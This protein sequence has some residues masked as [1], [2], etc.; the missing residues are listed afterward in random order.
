MKKEVGHMLA[1][2]H[3]V[4]RLDRNVAENTLK[5][6]LL[7]VKGKNGLERDVPIRPQA[8]EVLAQAM[9]D[10]DRGHKLFIADDEKTHLVIKQIQNFIIRHRGKVANLDRESNMTFHGLRHAYTC[11]EYIKRVSMGM[12]EFKARK[13][14]TELLGHGRDDVTRVYMARVWNNL[15]TVCGCVIYSMSVG[16]GRMSLL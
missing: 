9:Q 8:R 13:E 6:G 1:C 7:H 14:V 12:N 10:T 2:I 11:E 16:K 15:N 3:E 5:S 4:L